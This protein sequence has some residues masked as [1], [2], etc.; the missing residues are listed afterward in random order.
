[1]EENFQVSENV[2]LR[3]I[4]G[5]AF[6]LLALPILFFAVLTVI[7]KAHFMAVLALVSGLFFASLGYFAIRAGRSPRVRLRVTDQGLWLLPDKS[8]W[9]LFQKSEQNPVILSWGDIVGIEDGGV[10]YGYR[11]LRFL[12]EEVRHQLN[13]TFLDSDPRTIVSAV[14]QKLQQ[15]RKQL[16]EQSL[17]LF[18]RSGKWRVKAENARSE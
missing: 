17:G 6:F 5:G 2:A 14:D 8:D 1:M 10:L 16:V 18:A 3:R 12:T 9:F 4:L 15:N 13:T 7:A 11:R